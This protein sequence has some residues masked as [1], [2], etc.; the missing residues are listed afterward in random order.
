M[1]RGVHMLMGADEGAAWK[2]GEP[3]ES[4]MVFIG[5]DLP[6]DPLLQ[7]LEQ[8]VADVDAFNWEEHAADR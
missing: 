2:D 6:K 5:R 8:C 4:R 7:G 1:F 3:R